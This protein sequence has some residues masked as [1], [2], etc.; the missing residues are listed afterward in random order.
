MRRSRR[1]LIVLVAAVPLLIVVSAL[2]YE[3]GMRELEGTPRSFWD[4]MEWAAETLTTTGYGAD[5]RWHH[6][7]MV[8]LV[9]AT[10]WVGVFFVF[11]VFPIYVIPFL[12]ERF[13]AR[14]PRRA[15][16]LDRHVVVFRYGPAV[17]SAIE[18]LAERAVPVLVA[19]TRED[20]ARFLLD[21][22]VH[23][24]FGRNEEEL[25]GVVGLER[26][27]A[28]IGNGRDEENAALVLGA[29]QR[30]FEGEIV[31]LVEEPM[32]RKP[33]ALA[34]ASA[35]YTPRHILAAALAARASDRISPRL[36]GVQQ[37]GDLQVREV[38]VR[39]GSELASRTLGEARLGARTGTI[40]VG[41]WVG[42]QLQT[43]LDAASRLEPRGILVAVGSE[44]N[45]VRL[46]A[47]CAGSAPAR[48]AGP[49]VVAGFGEVGRKVRQLLDDAGEPVWSVDRNPVP[50]VDLVA[51]VLDPLVLQREEVRAARAVVLA[52]DSD[53]LTL[54]AT[55]VMQDLVPEA[56]VI[57]RVNERGNVEKIHR[58]GADFA[59][60]LSQV[61][62]QMLARRLLGEEALTLD[63]RLKVVKLPAG[64]LAGRRLGELGLR[65]RTG[66]SILAVE[67]AGELQVELDRT[68]QFEQADSLF[69]FGSEAALHDAVAEVS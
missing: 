35:V 54:L 33:M 12:E 52:L 26:A 31:A 2:L 61:S 64:P 62:G 18:L 17:E 34:G 32:H 39:A 19:E 13:E 30:G 40:V 41:Q 58:A 42:G 53:E 11:L 3:I 47:L 37:L 10:Q 1:R 69:L 49:F 29:R 16:K 15:P 24:V 6:P 5:Q 67:R 8:V 4:S 50:G 65:E 68:F 36:A 66:A 51:N 20:P 48:P 28:I 60:S 55:V 56:P 46:E 59:L 63:S 25:L 38:R 14:L 22:D 45:L 9:M 44:A 43:P 27:R 23:V 57:A 7:A 21:R